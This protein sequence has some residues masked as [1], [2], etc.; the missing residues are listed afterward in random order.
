LKD[1]KS[2]LR[3]QCLKIRESMSS[4]KV[5]TYSQAVCDHLSNWPIFQQANTL[6]SFLAFRNEI[7]LGQLFERWPDKRWLVPRILEDA[8][9]RPSLALHPYDPSRL[10][11]HRFGMLEPD[12]SLPVADPRELEVILVPG[13]AFDRQ[14]GR[15]GFGGGFYDCLLPQAGRINRVGVTYDELVLDA[16]PM[17]PWD[18]CVDWLATPTG[19]IKTSHASSIDHS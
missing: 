3:R 11:R 4:A 19:L 16:V 9:H 5:R 18:C 2:N 6:L 7:D 17:Q 14:G 8:A 1:T 15:L 10:V 13:V 12:P